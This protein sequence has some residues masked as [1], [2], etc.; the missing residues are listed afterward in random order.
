MERE[1]VIPARHSRREA[2]FLFWLRSVSAAGGIQQEAGR[3]SP[4]PLGQRQLVKRR[5]HSLSV[6][7]GAGGEP[8]DP[9]GDAADGAGTGSERE[10]APVGNLA[11]ERCGDLLEAGMAR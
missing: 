1:T 6:R 5:S 9:V 11:L 2:R 7:I 3:S 4:G 10:R 8:F